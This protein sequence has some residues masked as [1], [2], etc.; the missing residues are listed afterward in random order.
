MLYSKPAATPIGNAASHSGNRT[1]TAKPSL[2]ETILAVPEIDIRGILT[3]ARLGVVNAMAERGFCT[4]KNVV[5]SGIPKWRVAVE[6][7][8]GQL[9]KD[10][11]EACKAVGINA[12]QIIR[13][14]RTQPYVY[15]VDREIAERCDIEINSKKPQL[16]E[17]FL[18]K[19]L[20]M[21]Y[22]LA[23]NRELTPKQIIDELKIV[24]SNFRARVQRINE[25]CREFGWPEAVIIEGKT[26][27]RRCRINEE[28]SKAHGF[29]QI[30]KMDFRTYFTE[31]QIKF[32]EFLIANPFSNSREMGRALGYRP[33]EIQGILANI[34]ARCNGIESTIENG[35][36]L[37][38]M[39]VVGEYNN[40]YGFSRE[41]YKLFGQDYVKPDPLRVIR[42]KRQRTVYGRLRELPQEKREDTAKALGMTIGALTSCMFW[43]NK[44]LETAGLET[45]GRRIGKRGSTAIKVIKDELIKER[46]KTGCWDPSVLDRKADSNKQVKKALKRYKNAMDAT[47]EVLRTITG[48]EYEKIMEHDARIIESLDLDKFDD[49]ENRIRRSCRGALARGAERGKLIDIIERNSET[50]EA[51]EQI[52]NERDSWGIP[53]FEEEVAEETA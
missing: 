30:V 4:A 12:Q 1:G 26:Y 39:I 40:L 27:S 5:D 43:I 38:L 11:H 53:T 8:R 36:E 14:T 31:T 20:K 22:L 23:T 15:Y 13:R 29:P 21:I 7:L 37:P 44:R 25:R 47:A 10:F 2:I 33:N 48:K 51:V 3:P 45:L 41:F 16:H 28:F 17:V 42:A 6:I 52:N 34:N 19:D 35:R 32:V 50:H 49:P 46:I 24:G 9:N 18:G